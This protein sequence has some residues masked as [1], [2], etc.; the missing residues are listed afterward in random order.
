MPGG[1]VNSKEVRKAI[2]NKLNVS[3]VT[4]SLSQG[5][6]SLVHSAA[7]SGKTFPMLVFSRASSTPRARAFTGE[8]MEDDLWQ[9]K[10]I[11]KDSSSSVAE[12]VDYRAGTVLH[13]QPLNISGGQDLYLARESAI[14]YT[15]IIEGQ[16]YR[17]HGHYYRLTYQ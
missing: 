6:A 4:G 1:T 5:S 2:Y 17:H 12:D 14:D 3:A 7:S 13:H 15:E 16:Q 9:V 11:T 10:V 8:Q